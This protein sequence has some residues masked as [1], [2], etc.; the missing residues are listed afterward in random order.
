VKTLA[1]QFQKNSVNELMEMQLNQENDKEDKVCSS[2]E[3]DSN[4]RGRMTTGDN[5]KMLHYWEEFQALATN[6]HPIKAEINTLC[7]LV[8]DKCLNHFKNILKKRE[9]QPTL[10]RFSTSPLAKTHRP[11]TEE[12]TYLE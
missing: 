2:E 10:D 1:S 9:F 3:D 12:E 7:A 8:E 11:A 5:K 4:K 6:W